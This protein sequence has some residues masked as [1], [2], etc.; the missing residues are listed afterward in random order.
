MVAGKYRIDC[1]GALLVASAE[2]GG[3]SI[4]KRGLF[5]SRGRFL[6]R[7][8]YYWHLTCGRKTRD[9]GGRKPESSGAGCATRRAAFDEWQAKDLA[10]YELHMNR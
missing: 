5:S 6:V 1:A 10:L 7:V 8:G 2:I 4:G 9:G 3:S